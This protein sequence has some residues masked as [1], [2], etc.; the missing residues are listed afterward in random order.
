[1]FSFLI[2]ARTIRCRSKLHVW[3]LRCSNPFIVLN[4]HSGIDIYDY[5]SFR[6]EEKLQLV[7]GHTQMLDKADRWLPNINTPFFHSYRHALLNWPAYKDKITR[8]SKTTINYLYK[9]STLCNRKRNSAL[10]RPRKKTTNKK[11]D[12]NARPTLIYQHN[13]IKLTS[14][15]ELELQFPSAPSLLPFLTFSN[16]PQFLTSST[17]PQ[18]LTFSNSLQFLTSSIPP[19]ISHLRP[20]PPLP[21]SPQAQAPPSQVG[22]PPANRRWRGCADWLGRGC[23]G[24]RSQAWHRYRG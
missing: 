14:R 9:Y 22:R 6:I 13:S 23:R 5:D 17:P 19:P 21:W 3:K 2:Y 24:W 12:R 15:S 1:M 11:R 7:Q 8:L 20:W 4:F 18:F 16:S 10:L